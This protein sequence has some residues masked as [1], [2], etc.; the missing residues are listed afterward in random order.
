[1]ENSRRMLVKMVKEICV[2]ND[3]ETAS[4]SYDWIFRLT[5]N[6]KS[7]HIFGYQFEKSSATAHLICSDKC[8]TSDILQFSNIPA[9]EH[10]FFMTPIDI[11]YVGVNGNWEK[12]INLLDKY[13]VLVCKSNEGSGGGN[14]YRV[15]NQFELENA[16]HKIYS[17]SRGMAV[18]PFYEIENE[19]RL[20]VLD[21]EVRL[22]YEKVLP[23]L[24]GDGT[25][26]VRDLLMLHA[27][28]N[29]GFSFNKLDLPEGSE[30]LVLPNN[31]RYP[32]IWKHNL[33]QGA[34]P[35][36]VRDKNLCKLLENLALKTAKAINI[37]FAS[38]DIVR[39]GSELAVLEVNSG[40]MMESF[41]QASTE[42]YEIAKS[43]YKSAI[44]S[45]LS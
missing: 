21:A 43:I 32:I 10:F 33:G 14:V 2:E 3:I 38:V 30:Q 18:C 22:I 7:A 9:V 16:A 35:A 34:S 45:M 28:N 44:E 15:T 41:S 40:V 1:M 39:I 29:P 25:S 12:I 36:E 17:H 20:I 27:Q 37:N 5:K 26:T 8:S 24:I 31:K 42:N 4:F 23:A 13:G 19:Y 6:N 11:K